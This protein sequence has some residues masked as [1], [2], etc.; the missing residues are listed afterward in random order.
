VS[1][2][3]DAEAVARAGRL[4][5]WKALLAEMEREAA[6]AAA[7]EA[8]KRGVLG[9]GAAV[10]VSS[11]V[12]VCLALECGPFAKPGAGTSTG[13]GTGTGTGAGTPDPPLTDPRPDG[14]ECPITGQPQPAFRIAGVPVLCVYFHE[15]PG[16]YLNDAIAQT[17]FPGFPPN[18]LH[19]EPNAAAQQAN[20]NAAMKGE[21]D[22]PNVP[23][24]E[25]SCDEYPYDS[26]KEGGVYDGQKANVR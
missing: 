4:A 25:L 14:Q 7:R 12:G 15:T 6:Q 16:I 24:F 19:F 8:L 3:A 5:V 2:V 11:G 18:P 23:G 10:V 21:P 9:L 1:A 22:F 26:S 20:R 13:T 17:R